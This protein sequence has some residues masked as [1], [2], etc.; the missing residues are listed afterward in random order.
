MNKVTILWVDDEIDGL[1]SQILFLENKGYEIVASSNGQDAIEKC[2]KNNYDLVFLDEQMPGF[3]GLETLAKI[4]EIKP[5]LPVVMITK[6]E[7][8]DLMDD[9][10]GAKI[11]DYLIKPV[12]PTQVQLVIKKILDNKRL[13]SEKSTQSYQREFQNISMTLSD[14]LDHEEW[15]NIYKK[16]IFWELE[17]GKSIDSSIAEILIQQKD[18]ANTQ[19]KKFIT[20]NYEEMLAHSDADGPIMSHNLLKKQVFPHFKDNKPIFLVVID[21]LRYD[22]WKMIEPVITQFYK[23]VEETY[24][25]SIL[26]TTTQYSRNAIFAG[27]SPYDIANTYP[28][29]WLDDEEEGGKNQHEE[30]L[31]VEQLKRSH[32]DV[33]HTYNK[34]T[35]LTAG[36]GL[37]DKTN[38]ML[39]NDLNV[40]VYNFVDMLSH[41]RS[42]SEIIKEL[43]NDEAAYRALT[44]SWF[45]HSPLMD[46]L[47]K[48]SEENINLI[49]TTDHGTIRVKE[50][51]KVIGDRFTSTNL[52]YKSGK[53]LNFKPDDVLSFRDP[54]KIGLPSPHVSSSFIFAKE[55]I[56]LIYPNNYNH[57][58]NLFRDTFQHGGISLEEMIVPIARFRT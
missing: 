13:V 28:S 58:V 39:N 5:N 31:L 8:E 55:D 38:E 10:I 19:F 32:I 56:Y 33:S 4:K 12:N 50:P 17:L 20:K 22:Q 43:A 11:S 45:E 3:T 57:F 34:I 51:S 53:N 21:N 27:M 42:E 49:I 24:M 41:T 7:E 30:A 40:I 36:K 29:K 2:K 6:S 46:M 37:V 25:Y 15:A 14:D 35:N 54:K 44:L 1:Q 9:A 16:L 23:P 26:P 48:L 52:R 18:E 47:E